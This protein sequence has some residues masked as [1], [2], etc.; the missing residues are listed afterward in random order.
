MEAHFSFGVK[1]NNYLGRGVADGSVTLN[2]DSI[3]GNLGISNP[4]Y[5]NSDKSLSVNTDI[6]DGQIERF[7]IQNK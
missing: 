2:E 3:K 4:N 6:R 7:W 5:K 1:E